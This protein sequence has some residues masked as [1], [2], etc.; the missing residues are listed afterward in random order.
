[1]RQWEANPAGRRRVEQRLQ[2]LW[3]VRVSPVGKRLGSS[4]GALDQLW[5]SSCTELGQH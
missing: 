1:M 5:G 3:T 4:W 2:V